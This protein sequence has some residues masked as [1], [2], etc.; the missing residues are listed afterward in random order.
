[1]VKDAEKRGILKKDK[2]IIIEPTSR[3]TGLH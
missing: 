3:N 1:M 2:S